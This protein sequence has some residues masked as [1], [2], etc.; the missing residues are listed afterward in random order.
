MAPVNVMIYLPNLLFGAMVMWI[1]QDILKAGV[2]EE[3][4]RG[5]W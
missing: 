3:R 2:G 1:G 5:S 4:G